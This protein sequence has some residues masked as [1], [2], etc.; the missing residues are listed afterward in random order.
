V[1]WQPVGLLEPAQELIAT[2]SCRRRHCGERRGGRQ[3]HRRACL[4]SA[5]S[6]GLEHRCADA[7]CRGASRDPRPPRRVP[8]RRPGP[9]WLDCHCMRANARAVGKDGAS[10]RTERGHR[11]RGG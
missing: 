5:A 4:G 10:H 6:H 3:A 1:R 11:S 8:L 7:L 9:L 2:E